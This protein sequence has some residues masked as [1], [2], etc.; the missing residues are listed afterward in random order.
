[1]KLTTAL[2]DL[3]GTLIH[4]PA[5]F[6]CEE[7]E[8]IFS[9]Y[10]GYK[11]SAQELY[12]AFQAFDFFGFLGQKSVEIEERFWCE[13]DLT[14]CPAPE[15]LPGAKETLGWLWEQGIPVAIVTARKDHPKQ[16]E[17]LL[18][19][20]QVGEFVSH[21]VC[22]HTRPGCYLDKTHLMQSACDSL[23]VSGSEAFY[24][25]DTP[26]DIQSA[27]KLELGLTI[28]V[29]TGHVLPSLLE[30]ES[31]DHMLSSLIEFPALLTSIK[32]EQHAVG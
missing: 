26:S 14:R 22:S 2:F 25:G 31:P 8:R 20:L 30:Q 10:L 13:L 1:M 19:Q 23:N 4:F 5:H 17:T 16:V 11:V 6:W 21:I 3:D 27:K 32:G 15:L 9:R 24:V 18:D 7:G 28:A 29:A 12:R